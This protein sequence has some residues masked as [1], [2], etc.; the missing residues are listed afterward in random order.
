MAHE[1]NGGVSDLTRRLLGC[2][3]ELFA[4]VLALVRDWNVAEDLFQEISMVALRKDLEGTAVERFGPWIREIA[5]RTVLNYWKTTAR[6]RLILS[7]GV[8]DRIDD[9]FDR[10][11]KEEASRGA[12]RLGALRRCLGRLPSHLRRIV[13]LRY[14]ESLPLEEIARRLGRSSGSVQVALSRIRV[15]LLECTRRL[16]AGTEVYPS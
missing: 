1:M 10:R 16:Q 15:R 2:R 6:S 9:V 3:D 11:E 5:R 12:E 4:Y 13:D 8:L 7:A 14:R